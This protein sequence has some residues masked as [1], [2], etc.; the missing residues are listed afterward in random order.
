MPAFLEKLTKHIYSQYQGR[1]GDICIVLPNRRAA[2]FIK[3]QLGEILEST[4]FLPGFY[5]IEDFVTELSGQILA[6]QLSLQFTLFEIHQKIEGEQARKIEEFLPYASWMLSDFNEIDMYLVDDQQ[7]FNHLGDTKEMSLW[8]P[9]GRPLNDFEKRY[10]A[11]IRSIGKYYN[12]LRESLNKDEQ[13]YQGM[14]FRNLA[15]NIGA[16]AKKMKWHKVIFAGFNA[17]TPA[18]ESIIRYL[19]NEEHAEIYWDADKYYTGQ[20]G[21]EAGEFLRGYFKN[22][23]RGAVLWEEDNFKQEKNIEIIGIPKNAGQVKYTGEILKQLIKEKTNLDNTAVV[24]PD[25]GL[26]I[27][28][29]NSIPGEAGNFNVTMGLSLTETPLFTLLDS[30]LSMHISAGRFAGLKADPKKLYYSKDLIRIFNHPWFLMLGNTDKDDADISTRIRNSNQVFQSIE[31]ITSYLGEQ[32]PLRKNPDLLFPASENPASLMELFTVLIDSLKSLLI[33]KRKDSKNDYA[34]ELEYLFRFR[35]LLKRLQ[36]LLDRY[37]S[38]KTLKTLQLI[39]RQLAAQQHIPFY[40]E[41]LQGLQVMGVLETRTLDFDTLI[42]LSVNEGTLPSG[43]TH[44]SFIPHDIKK[45]FK[46]P[47]YQHNNKVFAYHFYRLLQRAKDIYLLYN[48]ESGQ[49]GGEEKSRFITQLMNEVQQYSPGIRIRERF[50]SMPPAPGSKDAD[51]EIA[52]DEHVMRLLIKEAQKGFHPSSLGLYIN[53]PLQ[54]YLSRLLKIRETEEAD[55]TVDSRVLGI[56]IHETLKK[57]LYS[58]TNKPLDSHIFHDLKKH[59]D[60]EIDL[61]FQKEMLD[62]DLTHGKNLLIRSVAGKML[63]QLFDKE[64]T[65]LRD[66]DE[67]MLKDLE[68]RYSSSLEIQINGNTEQLIFAGTIDRVDQKRGIA[69]ILDYK[70]GFVSEKQLNPKTWENLIENPEYSKAF[71]LIMYS[72]LY[73]KTNPAEALQAGII[74]LRA[75]GKGPVLLKPPEDRDLNPELFMTFEHKLQE[76][77]EEIFNPSIPF[78]QAKDESRCKYCSYKEICN[79]VNANESTY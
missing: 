39:F 60:A 29:L 14:A 23:N 71:Q 2:L 5:A 34:I 59:L 63:R 30:I 1:L 37:G 66:G 8:N 19:L 76:M 40:G 43:G 72:W 7:L 12:G 55:E 50:L 24:L 51:I 48:T 70:T 18:E 28:L 26:L 20:T 38:I 10:L 74:S 6:D 41:P 11:F 46:L 45:S 21:Q 49:L 42:M 53:C 75:P 78:S 47:T 79:R 31:K 9:D 68:E 73:H 65:W 56:V 33:S 15:E 27:P 69:R 32:H 4:S 36:D 77:M 25:E 3:K 67:L 13:A 35:S 52:K 44:N 64:T 61:Q 22:L 17:L 57:L 62:G 58:H 16:A 54:F